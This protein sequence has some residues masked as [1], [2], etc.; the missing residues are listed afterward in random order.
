MS[1]GA[2]VPGGEVGSASQPG[3]DATART[4]DGGRSAAVEHV[5]KS[6]TLLV[7]VLS[8]VLLLIVGI[9]VIGLVRPGPVR[10]WLPAAESTSPPTTVP[11]TPDPTP[12]PV[13]AAA[14]DTG[15]VPSAAAVEAALDPLIRS[16]RL[17][18][19]VH[20][21]VLD[22]ASGELL[23]ARN[24]DVPT[25]PASTTKL[26]TAAAVL[27]ARGPAYRIGTRAVAG[28]SPGEVVLV[29]GGDA[30]LSIDADGQF[31]GAARLDRLAQQVT[32]ALGDTE[33]YNRRKNGSIA[34]SADPRR[35][36]AGT[37]T[38]SRRWDRCPGSRP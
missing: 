31:P 14:S 26:L 16:A 34:C 18:S 7:S 36:R 23:Y 28:S 30:T 11:S 5:G 2:A 8:V 32:K 33:S 12:T 37:P 35:H 13:L 4:D 24:A 20:A 22:V 6:R 38:T 3:A 27:S 9:A 10:H 15:K 25:T 21:T 1:G 29:G 19:T 17:G